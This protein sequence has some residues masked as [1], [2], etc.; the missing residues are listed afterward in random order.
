MKKLETKQIIGLAALAV[1]ALV[2]GKIVRD[3][4]KIREMAD[5]KEDLLADTEEEMIPFEAECEEVQVTEAETCDVIEECVE[6]APVIE[7]A[8]VVEETIE[9][10]QDTVAEAEEIEAATDST[11]TE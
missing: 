4:K 7:D 10:A 2:V 3:I 5:E 11:I 1:G 9:I 6:E 8:P